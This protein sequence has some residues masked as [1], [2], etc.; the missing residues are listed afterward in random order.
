MKRPSL[1][2]GIAFAFAIAIFAV[3]AW[4]ALKATLPYS[5]AFRTAVVV[6]YLSYSLYLQVAVRR[7][8]G[9]LTLSATNL[10]MTI[11]L[12]SLPTSNSVMVS[13]LVALVTVN[14]SLLFHRSI[15]SI[16]LDGFV[17]GVG[18]TF[19]GYLFT[20]TWSVPAALWSYFLLQSVFVM[21]PPRFS[22]TSGLFSAGE[23]DPVDPFQR[24]RRQAQ[25][26]LQ[27]LIQ[28]NSA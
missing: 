28:N 15:L 21:I 20:S 10:A 27:R 11:G 13:A 3:P 8:I 16:A 24:S 14:R 22:E 12:L 26:A 18:L 4:W 25:A 7:R 1:L 23:E 9:N 5:W 2:A 6:P 19:A 17:S